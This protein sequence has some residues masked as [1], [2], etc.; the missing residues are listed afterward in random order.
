MEACPSNEFA[1]TYSS[2][3]PCELRRGSTQKM[4][5]V[6]EGLAAVSVLIFTCSWTVQST[7]CA[8]L[9]PVG[10]ILR[11]Y[12]LCSWT[13]VRGAC[14]QHFASEFMDGKSQVKAKASL[15]PSQA[16]VNTS[17]CSADILR[18][19]GNSSFWV[20]FS[21]VFQGRLLTCRA[22]LPKA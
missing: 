9:S 13:N 8:F 2:V 16:G 20:G 18:A 7:V 12:F 19:N 22:F 15:D 3:H 5:L 6:A 21:F 1:D 17:S 11:F 4:Q 10:F 14:R